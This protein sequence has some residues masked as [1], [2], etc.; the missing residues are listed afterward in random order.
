MSEDPRLDQGDSAGVTD[1]LPLLVAALPIAARRITESVEVGTNNGVVKDGLD[2][3]TGRARWR[4][5][6]YFTSDFLAEIWGL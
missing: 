2:P 3:A 6:K 5:V 4:V 1:V